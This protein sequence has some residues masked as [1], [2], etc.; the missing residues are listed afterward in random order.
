MIRSLRPFLRSSYRP[1]ARL[2]ASPQFSISPVPVS[3]TYAASAQ[4]DSHV[5]DLIKQ[6]FSHVLNDR[7]A[8]DRTVRKYLFE[9]TGA[10]YG[11]GKARLGLSFPE[12]GIHTYDYKWLR[13]GC[14]CTRCVDPGTKQRNF[15]AAHIPSDIRPQAVEWDGQTLEILWENDIDG[16]DD[17]KTTYTADYLIKPSFRFPIATGPTR[18]RFLWR[19]ESMNELQ[20]WIS[21][22]DY[23]NDDARFTEAMKSLSVLGVIFVKDIPQ[24]RE[25]VEKIATRMGPLRNTFYGPTWDVRSIP[26]AKNVAYT[27]KPLD[28]HMD[29]MYMDNPP[30][31]QLLHCLENSCQGGESLFADSFMAVSDMWYKYPDFAEQLQQLHLTYTYDHDNAM[32]TASWPVFQ[33]HSAQRKSGERILAN[34]NYSPPFQSHTTQTHWTMASRGPSQRRNPIEPLRVFADQLGREEN[35]FKLKL[36]PGQCVIFENRRV[37]HSR[38]QFDNSTGKRWLAG[39]Y[40]DSDALMSCFRQCARKHPEAWPEGYGP[41]VVQYIANKKAKLKEIM[42]SEQKGAGKNVEQI[43]N[44]SGE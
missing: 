15:N 18:K 33:Y 23:M 40:V 39:A 42:G 32:Y 17:H 8:S 11:L 21:F 24:S 36:D 27:A 34:V 12:H 13:E 41:K 43:V 44:S 5:E 22:N 20:H 9:N 29:L 38:R 25:M 14:K 28:F 3:R 10:T 19:R 37:V 4:E 31:F 16:Y 2:F 35:I 30:G 6:S 26:D 1:S 7:R